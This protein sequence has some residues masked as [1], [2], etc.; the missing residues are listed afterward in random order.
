MKINRFE[1]YYSGFF[2]QRFSKRG[3]AATCLMSNLYSTLGFK[4]A[5]MNY[6]LSLEIKYFGALGKFTKFAFNIIP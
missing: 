4:Q 3:W 2:F 5:L 6:L 1:M